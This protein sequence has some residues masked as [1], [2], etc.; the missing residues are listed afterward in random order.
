MQ[1][2]A[3]R[4]CG[5]SLKVPDDLS[6][7]VVTCQFCG[8]STPLPNELLAIR[9]AQHRAVTFQQ[10]QQQAVRTSQE[11]QK[12]V[13]RGIGWM[14]FLFI[15]VPILMVVGIIVFIIWVVHDATK[16]IHASTTTHTHEVETPTPTVAPRAIASDS[17][18]TGE[19]RTTAQMKDL[20]AKGC[21]TVVMAPKQIQGER[22]LKTSFVTGG[23]CVRI[24]A[25]TGV[26]DNKLTLT[27]KNPLGEAIKTP[28]PATEVDFT[29]CPKIA[30][31]HPMTISPAT[32]DFYT[33]AAVDCPAGLKK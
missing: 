21:K 12:Q 26:A 28:D 33:L 3:C 11:Q 31:E 13:V 32:D 19:D 22:T 27:M 6:A 10:A 7:I 23:P 4:R 14:L 29:F 5:A 16:D 1:Q 2:L 25:N 30:G 18:S 20:Y 17:K 9:Q 24:L 15:G 8:E